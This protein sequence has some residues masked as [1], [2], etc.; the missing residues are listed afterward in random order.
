M[1]YIRPYIR[2]LPSYLGLIYEKAFYKRP[3]RISGESSNNYKTLFELAID[4][5]IQFSSF[6]LKLIT[7]VGVSQWFLTLIVST[8]LL[9]ITRFNI[10]YLILVLIYLCVSFSLFTL[11]I[12]SQYIYRI[13]SKSIGKPI[14]EISDKCG[15]LENLDFL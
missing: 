5:I 2:L 15:N 13:Y 10:N 7:Y 14:Y 8:F 1:S 11:T 6:P 9:V 3:N 12:I 4:G